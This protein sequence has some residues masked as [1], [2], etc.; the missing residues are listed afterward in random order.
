[1]ARKGTP[2]SS[3]QNPSKKEIC[4]GGCLTDLPNDFQLVGVCLG[5]FLHRLTQC[6]LPLADTG[7][8]DQVAVQAIRGEDPS[9]FSRPG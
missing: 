1:M 9:C 7:C 6:L 4:S 8:K 2:S 3:L 5:V